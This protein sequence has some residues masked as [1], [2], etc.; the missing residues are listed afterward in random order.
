MGGPCVMVC[1]CREYGVG[2]VVSL[3]VMVFLVI[4]ERPGQD[5]TS[6]VSS[7]KGEAPGLVVRAH[8]HAQTRQSK[9]P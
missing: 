5:R 1:C 8:Q 9:Q 7:G 2:A 3:W 4:G 6:S